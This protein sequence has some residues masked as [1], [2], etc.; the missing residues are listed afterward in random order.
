MS[1]TAQRVQRVQLARAYVLHQRPFRDT[2][3]IVE[4]YARE[5]GRMTVFARAARGPVSYTH[6][7][8]P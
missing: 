2:S 8:S 4:V 5:Y 7:R 6:L 1:R 3:L